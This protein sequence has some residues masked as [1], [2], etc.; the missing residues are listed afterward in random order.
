MAWLA[1]H[2]DSTLK[3]RISDAPD[4]PEFEFGFWPPREGEAL[5][6]VERVT[7]ENEFDVGWKMVRYGVRGWTGLVDEDGKPIEPKL[8]EVEID[9]RKHR[10]LV[11]ES[12]RLLI[13]NRLIFTLSEMAYAMNVLTPDAKKKSGLR[14]P[15]ASST[16]PTDASGAT[17]SGPTTSPSTSSTSTGEPSKGAPT[18]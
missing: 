8:E 3:Q 5:A 16:S 10:V 4:A 6:R 15:S 9:G 17:G 14:L 2:P 7:P 1:V 11:D 18:T 13:A 12:M